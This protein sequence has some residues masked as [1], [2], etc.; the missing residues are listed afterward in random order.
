MRAAIVE[1]PGGPE[2]LRLGEI[3]APGP[4]PGE[5]L[6]RVSHAAC[7]WGDIQKRQG[8][9]PDP[10]TYPAVLGAE[11]SG[12]VEACGREVT[13]VRPGA[14]V[15]AITGPDMLR[16]FAERVAVPAPYLIPLPHGFDPVLAAAFP[17]VSL[18]AWHLLHTAHEL[19]PG[20]T[21]LVHAIGGGVGL[22]LTQLARDA[23]ARVLGTVGAAAKAERPLAFG[24][25]RVV[26]RDAE[27]F[28]AAVLD[29][30]GGAGVDLVVDSLGAE[31]LERSFD[32]LRPFG[33]LIN[34]GEAAGEPDF[35]VRKTLYK[36]ST[37]MAGFEVLHAAPGSER[38]ARG[39]RAV[40]DA[41]V[42]G[43]LRIP[44]AA[45]FP[46]ARI[47]EAQALLESR[48]AAGKVVVRVAE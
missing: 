8:V 20:E 36:R 25:D 12:T 18:T 31:I 4:G 46:L 13:T 42:G 39:V 33:R 40:V 11:V 44:V 21:V 32:V 30:T 41:V 15:A 37:S 1:T 35:P 45:V 22:A 14:F 16:G 27:D 28:V 3:D 17:V 43:R 26:V 5:V 24:A 23:G 19:K 6:V 38:W 9:Y 29:E 47:R 48:R 2:A 10:V 7:N 34:I